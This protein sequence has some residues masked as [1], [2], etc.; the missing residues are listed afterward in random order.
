M[1]E[2]GIYF[3]P[4]IW[5][6]ITSFLGSTYWYNRKQLTYLSQ[7]LDFNNSNYKDSGY[8][9]WYKWREKHKN[10]WYLNLSLRKPELPMRF[11]TITNNPY[12]ESIDPPRVTEHD[13]NLYKN[14]QK[15]SALVFGFLTK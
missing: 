13:Y 12:I 5:G 10:S 14:H 6:I 4:G 2:E 3:P 7:A 8:W 9:L 1:N 15:Y 11:N